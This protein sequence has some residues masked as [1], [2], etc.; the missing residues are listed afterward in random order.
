M[1]AMKELV[2]DMVEIFERTDID[3]TDLEA[4]RAVSKGT[5]LER[6]LAS[7]DQFRWMNELP[8][9]K[10][11]A[12]LTSDE[13]GCVTLAERAQVSLEASAQLIENA[14]R[15]FETSNP[16]VAIALKHVASE[17][18]LNIKFFDELLEIVKAA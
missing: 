8:H 12:G 6:Y 7:F 16:Q 11:L 4:V 13:D 2:F 3:H 14:A 15:S 5:V 9:F 17:T 10:S 1:G 18:R